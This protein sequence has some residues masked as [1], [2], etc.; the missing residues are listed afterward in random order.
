MRGPLGSS[1]VVR[2]QEFTN[3]AT[4][5]REY[6]LSLEV[7]ERSRLEREHTS[8]VDYDEIAPL[9][10]ALDH[11]T[12]LDNTA[13]SFNRFQAD[14]RTH[15]EVQVTTY[16]TD[17]S[18]VV[19]AAVTCGSLERATAL[20]NLA[21]LDT[22]R[23][24]V[25][26]AVKWRTGCEGRISTSEARLGWRRTRLA[27]HNGVKIG[28]PRSV[29]P[30]PRQDQQSPTMN[31]RNGRTE[32]QINPG[33]TSAFAHQLVQPT[34]GHRRTRPDPSHSTNFTTAHS[35]HYFRGK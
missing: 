27:A 12:K 23:L 24:L 11:L 31:I 7:R 6:G 14:Y 15:G 5:E 3:A 10:K 2:S 8:F 28:R 33:R 30:Q 29:R 32:P 1:V 22:L 4:G 13:T 9:A 34:P 18:A 26:T 35:T 19:A 21:D 25:D 17:A 16:T 20:L